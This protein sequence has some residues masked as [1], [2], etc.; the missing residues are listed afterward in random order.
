MS[1]VPPDTLAEEPDGGN[2]SPSP[3]LA[4]AWAGRPARAT[5]TVLV[6]ARV[7][8]IGSAKSGPAEK[9]ADD[10]YRKV[11]AICSLAGVQASAREGQQRTKAATAEVASHAG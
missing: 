3:D 4:R 7:N 9:I 2:L 11:R 10:R 5:Q 8:K 1:R 6:S